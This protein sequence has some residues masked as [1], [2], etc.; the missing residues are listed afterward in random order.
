[1]P[2]RL[3]IPKI[4]LILFFCNPH[5][6]SSKVSIRQCCRLIKL[7]ESASHR[8]PCF[9]FG[10]LQV[11]NDKY[12]LIEMDDLRA[13]RVP[14]Q[15]YVCHVSSAGIFPVQWSLKNGLHLSPPPGVSAA[16]PLPSTA[17]APNTGTAN[18]H[19]WKSGGLTL[20]SWSFPG[21]DLGGWGSWSCITTWAL[22]WMEW[23]LLACKK[24]WFQT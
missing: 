16:P 17:P 19:F 12:F 6:I 7:S 2:M 13:E 11:Y 10:W 18:I 1:M 15:R 14:S 5:G 4:L 22:E 8:S 9:S 3:W 21:V 20:G 23:E 24:C